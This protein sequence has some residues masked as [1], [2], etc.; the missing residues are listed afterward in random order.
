M[1][2]YEIKWKRSAAK[3]LKK[4]HKSKIPSLLKAVESLSQNPFPTGV[5]KLSGSDI[6]YRIRVGTYRI[7]YDFYNDELIIEIIRVRHRK[8][9]YE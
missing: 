9:V 7:V 3:E 5:K 4:I 2:S 6:T 1:A 8:D